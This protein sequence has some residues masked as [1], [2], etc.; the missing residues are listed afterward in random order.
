MADGQDA[1]RGAGLGSGVSTDT[2]TRF[3]QDFA[4]GVLQHKPGPLQE[5]HVELSGFRQFTGSVTN[6]NLPLYFNL[7]KLPFIFR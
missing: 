3:Q 6:G 7:L 5:L 2:R 1:G 4:V